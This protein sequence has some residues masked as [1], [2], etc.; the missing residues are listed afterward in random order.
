MTQLSHISQL[1]MTKRAIIQKMLLEKNKKKST[2]KSIP[3]LEKKDTVPLSFAQER[4]WFLDQLV[5]DN[6]FYN[7]PMSLNL[8]GP[9]NISAL[10][11]TLMAIIQ[12]HETLRTK[13]KVINNKPV[14]IID[15][16]I[17]EL[18]QIIDL[19]NLSEAGRY[20]ETRNIMLEESL[21]PFNLEKDYMIR[22]KLLLIDDEEYVLLITMHHIASD[23]W[24]LG[25]LQKEIKNFYLCFCNKELPSLPELPIQYA[26]FAVWQREWLSGDVLNTQLSYWKEKLDGIESLLIP[27]DYKR[28]AIQTF[29]GDSLPV[30]IKFNVVEKLR[31]ISRDKEGSLY[32]VLLAAFSILLSWYSGQEDIAVGSPI[33]NRNRK[34]IENLIGFFVNTL[35]MRTD[36]SDNPTFLELMDRVRITALDAYDNQDLPFEYLVYKLQ[37]ERDMSRN[38]L[39]QIGLALQ[40]AQVKSFDMHNLSVRQMGVGPQTVKFDMEVHLWEIPEGLGGY[41]AYATDLFKSSTISRFINH[42]KNLLEGISDNPG[43]R[44]SEI[45]MLSEEE[46][47][48][49]LVEFSNTSVEYPKEKCIHELFK[50]QVQRSPDAVAIVYEDNRLSYH[51][52]DEKSDY[53]AG[54][55]QKI[56]ITPDIN[57]G[58]CMKQSLEMVIAILGVL[59]SGGTYIPM[60]PAY[61]EERL[62]YM[63]NDSQVTILLT[64]KELNQIFEKKKNTDIDDDILIIINLDEEWNNIQAGNKKPLKL[65]TPDNIAYIIYTSGST[66]KPKGVMISHKA[67]CNHML[68][69]QAAFNYDGSDVFFQKTSFSFDASIWEFFAPLMVG[70][71]L[72]IANSE[73]RKYATYLVEEILK[74]DVTVFQAVPSLLEVVSA[75]STFKDCSSLRHIFCGGEPLY[76]DLIFPYRAHNNIK[77]H[78][79]YGPTEASIDATFFDIGNNIESGPVSIGRPIDNTQVYIQNKH[80]HITPIGVPGE[81]TI[82]GIGLARGYYNRPEL[83]G[84]KFVPNPHS[85]IPGDRMYKTG[86]LSQYQSNGN[87]DFLGRIDH[88][89][90]IRGYRIELGE[91]ETVMGEHPGVRGSLVLVREDIPGDK[92]L[93]GY[94]LPEMGSEWLEGKLDETK[95]DHVSEWRQLHNETYGHSDDVKDITFNITGWNSSYTGGAIPENEMCE[96]VDE[97]VGRIKRL[98]PNSV[99]EIGCGTGLL[100]SR[101]A[102]ECIKY[103][104]TDFSQKVIQY[105]EYMKDSFENLSHVELLQVEAD[106]FSE[107]EDG[108]FDTVIINSVIQYF[109]GI[110]YLLKV[111]EGALKSVEDG[112]YIFIGDVRNYRLLDLYHTSVQ[113]FKAE[114]TLTGIELRQVI[115]QYIS[116]EE[117]LLVDPAFFYKL[118]EYFPNV[119]D[120][121]VYLKHGRY[122]NELTRFRYDVVIEVGD[123][124]KTEEEI[125][126]I[127][128]PGEQMSLEKVGDILS[129]SNPEVIGFKSIPNA[130]LDRECKVME[131][132][133]SDQAGNESV[134]QFR[135]DVALRWDD[136]IEPDDIL[137]LCNDLGYWVEIC[138]SSTDTNGGYNAV[139]R[140][141]EEGKIP[142]IGLGVLLYDDDIPLKSLN[143]YSNNPLHGKIAGRLIPELRGYLENKLPDYM[144]PSAFM[145]LSEFPLNPNGKIDRKRLPAPWES[146]IGL[147]SEY[148]AP[149]TPIEK[150]LAKI[151]SEVLG[152]E[153]IGVHDNFF[154]IGGHS[155][156]ATQ[157]I[158]RIRELFSIEIPVKAIFEY[159]KIEAMGSYI[160][161]IKRIA[162]DNSVPGD[163]VE[164]MEVGKL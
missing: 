119:S 54:Y 71:Q 60:D 65:A 122:Q 31:S 62:N 98:N 163:I 81:L 111:L 3:K 21:L 156:L 124:R 121:R 1:S 138:L 64:Q 70:S 46:T 90:K 80:M 117:E 55:L 57:V 13:F 36:L 137:D 131:W 61:P 2:T 6:S 155:L 89:V 40:N 47:Y 77:I 59:K 133:V 123:K 67:I 100:L 48:T 20:E 72:L 34:D 132:L 30:F 109:P 147:S 24:S 4:L 9:L 143:E 142:S 29:R 14:Q 125:E 22:M 144:I 7:I 99:L 53:L 74:K 18:L 139:L 153:K 35:V 157:V 140:R 51:E 26:D 42:F 118:K 95:A 135:D 75:E 32:M 87:I 120:V 78:N 103:L 43:Q 33:A 39:F 114:P 11:E 107:I 41:I 160:D 97:T 110:D 49:L 23:G 149:R 45:P 85:D 12:R 154:E 134:G 129:E 96:W 116:Q 37:P 94:V 58:I 68:W 84:E 76:Y 141:Q 44:I 150:E 63:I 69:M 86:D 158:S 113:E 93:A 126:W 152:V 19:S 162:L 25:V 73:D 92:R 16:T 15:D 112:G 27:T 105:M 146:R 88:Q 164:Y 5:S 28:P 151:W 50:E 56:G 91:I 66:G 104:G 79:L 148:V 159:P 108:I 127:D 136:G 82:S 101:I 102:P 128:W 52:L 83:T 106:D 130:R 115:Q 38:P 161:T 17:P 8:R 10:K 145:I